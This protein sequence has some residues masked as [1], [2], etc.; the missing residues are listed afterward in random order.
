[1]KTR[2]FLVL[3]LLGWGLAASAQD[4]N[5]TVEVT[6][7]YEGKLLETR[8]PLQKMAV[9]DSVLK[10]DLK[11][12]YSVFDNPYKGG[13]DFKP[14]LMSLRPEADS[15]HS[16]NLYLRLGA[17]YTLHPVFDLV[18][19]PEF[20]GRFQMDVYASHRSFF[21]QYWNIFAARQDDAAT[22]YRLVADPQKHLD[23]NPF[24]D[25]LSRSGYDSQTRAGVNGRYDWLTG[26]ATFDIGYN[27]IH[28]RDAD[29]GAAGYNS[30][31]LSATAGSNKE[32]EGYFFY[33]AA[34]DYRYNADDLV[35]LGQKLY[36][37]D[38]RIQGTFGPV[39]SPKNKILADVFLGISTYG[40]W[41][42]S[43]VGNLSVTPKYI[44]TTG[45]F[46]MSLGAKI[47]IPVDDPD[48]F[49]YDPARAAAGATGFAVNPSSDKQFV[50]PDVHIS[51]DVIA[52][53]MNAFLRVTGGDD[54]HTYTSLKTR[55]HFFTPLYGRELGPFSENSKERI[56]AALGI[57]G[58]IASRFRYQWDVVGY[59]WHKNGLLDAVAYGALDAG[60]PV[61]LLPAVAF[62]DYSRI[63]SDLRFA[64][65]GS[66]VLADGALRYNWNSL[67]LQDRQPACFEPA[68]FS[69]EFRARYN[70][71]GRIYAGLTG[72]F[73]TGRRGY[74]QA[75]PSSGIAQLVPV[76]IPGWFDLGLQAEFAFTRKLSFWVE[77]GNLLFQPIQRTPLYAERGASVTAGLTLN[78]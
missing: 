6:R 16:R 30:V 65:D 44:F 59:V 9:P 5:P 40:G 56:H 15:D 41:F 60:R 28:T 72:E 42:T 10:F 23:A 34:L 52:D 11:F 49:V 31:F 27:G 32:G 21:G 74:A 17:G 7:T 48:A 38:F 14:Y 22:D 47:A 53:Y 1:M 12:D 76:R 37:H 19:S 2:Y 25:V 43:N 57:Q 70:W 67:F 58:N 75:L 66:S 26:A 33:K 4:L 46:E 24:G 8:K 69:G 3:F 78:L 20:S 61:G 51:Y 55:N 73:A 39:I 29:L 71:K 50:Y 64:W 35:W 54:F 45:P 13:F 62:R 63:Y 77:A 18:W 68:A 36:S